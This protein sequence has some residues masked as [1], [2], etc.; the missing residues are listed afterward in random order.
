M[1]ETGRLAVV[2]FTT[3]LLPKLVRL[4]KRRK[5]YVHCVSVLPELANTNRNMCERLRLGASSCAATS[6]GAYCHRHGN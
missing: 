4:K 3:K 2:F 1:W 5:T 6:P